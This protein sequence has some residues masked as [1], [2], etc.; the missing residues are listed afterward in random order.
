MRRR[1]G[2]NRHELHRAQHA[3]KRPGKTFRG[4]VKQNKH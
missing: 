3:H 2:L 4:V 1:K